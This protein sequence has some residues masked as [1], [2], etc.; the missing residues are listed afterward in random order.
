MSPL[1]TRHS[2]L[3]YSEF[4]THR[5]NTRQTRGSACSLNGQIK[6]T[7]D[8]QTRS[9]QYYT[10]GSLT[11]LGN[12]S[13]RD[14]FKQAPKHLASGG[15][16]LQFLLGA[17]HQREAQ[18]MLTYVRILSMKWGQIKLLWKASF[19]RKMAGIFPPSLSDLVTS[20]LYPELPTK[21]TMSP[22]IQT[23]KR[24]HHL[25]WAP[26]ICPNSPQASLHKREFSKYG[27][28]SLARDHCQEIGLQLPQ[29]LES[30]VPLSHSFSTV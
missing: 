2:G 17:S 25:S 20:F 14:D 6:K 23:R 21:A 11:I 3:V 16:L 19:S 29:P 8:K 7:K 30:W 26:L 18:P 27:Y 22:I 24:S 10:Q 9:W 28:A 1:W 13:K 12:I 15:S 4:L 5:R